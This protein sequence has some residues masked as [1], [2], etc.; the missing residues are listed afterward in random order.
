[1]IYGFLGWS[2]STI[3][4]I[5]SDEHINFYLNFVFI[6]LESLLN[7]YSNTAAKM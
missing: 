3:T 2:L 1:M 6:L 5:D 4:Y 7:M